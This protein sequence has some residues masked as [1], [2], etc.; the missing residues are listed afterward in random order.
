ME[1]ALLLQVVAVV[2]VL[3]LFAQIRPNERWNILYSFAVEVSQ[4]PQSVC[5]KDEALL[6]I[7][8]ILVTSDTSHL[9]ISI[10]NDDAEWNMQNMLVT[11]DT[12]HLE[13]SPLNDDAE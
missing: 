9:E 3:I 10:L 2:D 6:N 11:L 1:S 8:A 7:S 13:I 5:A 12:S 4:T